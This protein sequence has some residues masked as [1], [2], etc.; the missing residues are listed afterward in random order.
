MDDTELISDCRLK[1]SLEDPSAISSVIEPA[2]IGGRP[3]GVE[4]L[5]PRGPALLESSDSDL[6]GDFADGIREPR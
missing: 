2:K 5:L 4:G 1:G 6:L 3:M